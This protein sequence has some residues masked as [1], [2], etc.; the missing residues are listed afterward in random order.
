MHR[1][2]LCVC[3]CLLVWV[4]VHQCVCEPTW[5]RSSGTQQ[6]ATYHPGSRFFPARSTGWCHLC[7]CVCVCVY[8]WDSPCMKHPDS[9]PSL[10]QR[11][12]S[13]CKDQTEQRYTELHEFT[14]HW[15]AVMVKPLSEGLVL[16][17]TSTSLWRYSNVYCTVTLPVNALNVFFSNVCHWLPIFL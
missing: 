6:N 2:S 10:S 5:Q 7:D 4:S 15:A 3:L 11:F 1:G 8:H 9:I 12:L 13:C 17:Q 16:Q 14:L